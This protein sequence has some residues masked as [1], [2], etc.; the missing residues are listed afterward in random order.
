MTNDDRQ[1]TE[2]L[3]DLGRRIDDKISEFEAEGPTQ[4]AARRKALD[5]R[6]EHTRLEALYKSKHEGVRHPEREAAVASELEVM[7]L[8]IERWLAGLDKEA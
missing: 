7:M 3:A 8:S 4:V 2:R 1:L 6:M 5:M